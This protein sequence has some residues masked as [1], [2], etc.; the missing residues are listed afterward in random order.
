MVRLEKENI[1]KHFNYLNLEKSL[2]SEHD[3]NRKKTV[4][5]KN[6]VDKL[7]SPSPQPPKVHFS[8]AEDTI[9]KVNTPEPPGE[10]SCQHI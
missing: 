10:N 9:T 8:I 7:N 4:N 1:G 6:K 2:S 3:Q 5:I